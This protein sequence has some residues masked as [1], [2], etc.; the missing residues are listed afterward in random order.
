MS[1]P[2]LAVLVA[3]CRSTTEPFENASTTV[4]RPTTGRVL[5]ENGQIAFGRDDPTTGEPRVFIVSPDGVGEH[6]LD[7]PYPAAVP[8][9]SPDG[10]KLLITVFVPDGLRP[11]VVNPDGSGLSVL[12]VPQVPSEADRYCRAWSPDSG[13]LLCTIINFAGDN[14]ADGIYSIRSSDGGAPVR[15]TINPY[16]P[17]GNFGGGDLPGSYSPDGTRFVFMRA[18]PGAGPVPDRNQKGALFV[19]NI[20][21]TGLRQLTPYGL[22]NSH[23]DGLAH[24]SP[25][26]RDILFAGEQGGLF[27]VQVEG[28]GVRKIPL[29]TGG[30]FSFVRAPDWSPDGSRIVFSMFLRK[31]GRFDLYTANADGSSLAL[32]TH[33]PEFEDFASWGASSPIAR[34][35]APSRAREP[36]Q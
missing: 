27:T 13:R 11:A 25:D 26:G 6:Q 34:A 22:P 9:W 21:G 33:T 10:S 31:T 15:L 18:K 12:D 2:T 14:A 5:S 24:W 36:G 32:L 7:V 19:E 35:M 28:T 8:V 29:E 16:P 23:D 1:W 3:A 30:S 17:V 20:D 4:A